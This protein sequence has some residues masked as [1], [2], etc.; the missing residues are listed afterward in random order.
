MKKYIIQFILSAVIMTM[1]FTSCKKGF[2][3]NGINDNPQDLKDPNASVLF[4]SVLMS[5]AYE[6]GGDESRFPSIFMQ[7]VTGA[8]NQSI[9]AG[10]YNISPDDVDNMWTFG[11]YGGIMNNAR[12]LIDITHANNQ[13][14]YHAAGQITMANLLMRVTDLWGD[15]PYSKAFMGEASKNA[16]F[17]PQQ[18]LYDT[19]FMYLNN[20]VT[21]I[22]AGDE[23]SLQPGSAQDDDYI[24]HGDMDQWIKFAH[25]LKARAFIHL[26][27]QVP[28]YY[29]SVLK[30][31]PLAFQ[32]NA[33]NAIVPF[34]GS[35]VNTQNPTF[36][37]ND[38]R[39]D[40][41]YDGTLQ[42]MLADMKDPRFNVYYN[43]KDN[44]VLGALYGSETSPINLM[45]YEELK[46]IEAEA[47]FQKG[48]KAAA[49]SAYNAAV[50]A[51][52]LRTVGKADYAT[53]VQ[54]SAGN[55]TLSDIMTQK[56]IALFLTAEVWTDWR[57]TGIP[58]LKAPSGNVTGGVIP[59]ALLYPSSE[60]RYNSNTPKGRTLTSKV[61]WDK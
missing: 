12:D 51:S 47:Q 60:Q 16:P 19:I 6:Y 42:T 36:Q 44:T 2:F 29:D 25:A 9:S 37:F 5:S 55:I 50:E 54:K 26:V 8:A 31:I 17:D 49:A 23:S 15:V 39:G 24:Y 30:E 13:H 28:A 45:T 43:S 59:R 48:N 27:K 40:I 21:E 33:D 35:S 18:V 38:Q 34:T 57:R 58:V 41:T 52:L 22:A 7:Q 14:Y 10:I 46:F 53:S 61:W 11:F 56:Y 4:P 20:A 3:Y 1:S 32:S